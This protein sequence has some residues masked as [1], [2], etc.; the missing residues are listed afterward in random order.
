MRQLYDCKTWPYT[1]TSSPRR[2]AKNQTLIFTY[3]LLGRV[4]TKKQGSTTLATWTYDDPTVLY[5]KGK[6]TQVVDQATTTKF[7][8]DQ[9]GRTTQTQRLQL[10]VWYT[11][12]QQYDALNRITSETFPDSEVV[13]YSYNEAGW[14]SSVSGYINAITY[15]ARG[16]KTALTYANN[17]T[18]T[19]TYDPNNFRPTNRTTQVGYSGL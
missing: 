18:T 17:L 13:N 9:V 4:S 2:T 5:S 7:T 6:V 12:A 16:Q 11:M 3:D 14:L 10:G 15:N 8:Y 19:W 1:R